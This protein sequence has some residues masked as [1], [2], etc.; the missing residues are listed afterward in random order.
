MHR[1]NAL[2][3]HRWSPFA[4]SP[5]RGA[6]E[7]VWLAVVLAVFVSQRAAISLLGRE[8]AAADARRAVYFVTTA[9]LVL[10]AL[11]FRRYLGSLLVALGIALNF[12]PMAS[13]GGLMPV[14]YETVRDSG[15]LPDV[16]EADI[17][18]Q[19]PNSKDVVLR[20]EDISF[21]WLCDRFVVTVPV[22]GTNIYSLGDFVA[23]AGAGAAALQVV[24]SVFLPAGVRRR[25]AQ[26]A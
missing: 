24:A 23:F 20:A 25:E 15:L 3:Q 11:H 1:L 19:V 16:S 21:A 13:H 10:L 9:L 17:G 22:Y 26:P 5:L 12:V 18:R 2:V 6:G 4:R 8:G 14:D 7:F